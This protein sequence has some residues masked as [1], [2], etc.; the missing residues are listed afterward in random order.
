MTLS[1][2]AFAVAFSAHA[3][4]S[5]PIY[6]VDPLW[7]KP[8]PNNLINGDIASV[9][10]DSRDHVWI[11][12]R[13]RTIAEDERS[14]GNAGKPDEAECCR[15]AAPVIEYDTQGNFVQAWG[16]PSPDGKYDW[17]QTEHG[18]SVDHKDNVWICGN[19]NNQ[20]LKFTRDGKFLLQIGKPVKE[21]NSL[22]TANLNRP[23]EAVVWPATNEVFVADGYGNRRV[24]VFD[25]DTGAFKRMWGAYGNKPDDAAPRA[26]PQ[27]RDPAPQQFDLVH[28]I[29]I[30]KDGTVYVN[31]RRN[32]RIQAFT[33][34][35]KFLKE[36]FVAK[37]TLMSSGT[38]FTMDFSADAQEKYLFV[39]DLPSGRIRVLD[40][41]TL[42][43]IPGSAIGSRGHYAGQFRG[44]HG[45]ATDSKGNIYTVDTRN[46]RL[47]KFVNKGMSR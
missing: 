20:C 42:T 32:N 12:Q 9:G 30:S 4:E 36:G 39:G 43:E 16:G 14:V 21:T 45:L 1:A 13:P 33:I 26:N 31:D 37:P 34:Q 10:V 23:A 5:Y 2:L 25:A 46:A 38:S 24:A 11:V 29:K 6:E 28:G 17:P 40:R 8:L 18:I 27:K 19:S 7:P 41:Q 3:A 35:G 22:D 44:L 47:Q 15:A